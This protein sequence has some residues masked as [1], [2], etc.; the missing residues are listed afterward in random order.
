MYADQ[1]AATIK[2]WCCDNKTLNDGW[3][4]AMQ[5]VPL[6]LQAAGGNDCSTEGEVFGPPLDCSWQTVTCSNLILFYVKNNQKYNSCGSQTNT[7]SSTWCCLLMLFSSTLGYRT[8]SFGWMM[9]IMNG[10]DG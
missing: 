5:S 10:M 8:G 9:M 4:V 6:D 3:L 2:N 7:S 1:M